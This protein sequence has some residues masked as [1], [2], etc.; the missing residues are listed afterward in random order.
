MF[1]ALRRKTRQV[2]HDPVLRRWLI[3]TAFDGSLRRK[4]QLPGWPPYLGDQ[5]SVSRSMPSPASVASIRPLNA[6]PPQT[7]LALDL[8]GE[9]L[10]IR[11]DDAAGVFSRKYDDIETFLALQRFAWVPLAGP[12]IDESWVDALWR[13]WIDGY[14]EPSGDWA[15][16]PYTVAERAINILEFSRHHG[17]PGDGDRTLA[18]LADHIS[19]IT[20]RLEYFGDQGTGNHL[21]NNGRGLY[22]LGLQLGIEAAADR[23]AL[24]MLSEADRLFGTAGILREGS[25]HYHLL[26][27]RNYVSAWLISRRYGRPETEQFLTIVQRALSALEFLDLPARFPLV[28]DISPDCPP[29]FLRCLLPGEG[30]NSGW[31]LLLSND[32]CEAVSALKRDCAPVSADQLA[33]NGW[34]RMD[35]GP[36]S[37]VWHVAPDGWPPMPGHAHQDM[38]SFEL[39]MDKTPV[40]IDPGRGSYS[41]TTDQ[42]DYVGG[43]A[44]N[45]LLVDGQDPYP[46]NKPYYSAAFRSAVATPPR[47]MRT[48]DGIS[49]AHSGYSRLAGVGEV[50]RS[51][52]FTDR[53]VTIADRIEGRD[54]HRVTRRLHTFLPVARDGGDVVLQGADR[55]IRLNSDAEISLQAGQYWTAYGRSEPAT[56]IDISTSESLPK[57]LRLSISVE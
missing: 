40:F 56:V 29:A 37:C 57:R 46:A 32:E 35:T 10:S 25:T 5:S 15:W 28:G 50:A 20:D 9:A 47:V 45:T 41:D 1:D 3:R 22:F 53:E 44:H 34:L 17:V 13:H 38:G 33:G 4:M 2:T 42:T 39:H 8:P 27:V 26:M 18:V 54:V 14:G 6:S 55:K 52:T 36:W 12:A 30:M 24:I 11:P 48:H 7:S 16:H 19:V 21:S 49:I 23:G 31:A 43:L 51:A